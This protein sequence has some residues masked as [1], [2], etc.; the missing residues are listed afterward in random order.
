MLK[1]YNSFTAQ[2]EIFKPIKA[3]HISLYVC[4]ITVYDYCHLG[5]ARVF[6]CFD[7]IVRYLR[8]R[9]WD[10]TYIRNITDVD[11]KIIKRAAERDESIEV[12]TGYFIEAMHEDER[13]LKV[14]SP[15]KEPRATQH[16]QTMI[17]MI[18]KLESRGVAYQGENGDLFFSV[19]KYQTYGA[20]S[21][22]DLSE[23]KSGSRVE[24]D[25][26]KRN[27]LDFVL[28]KQAKEGETSWPSPW[29]MGRP[30]WHIE[31]SAMSTKCLGHTFDIHGGGH[32]LLFPHHENERAQS[33]CATGETFVNTW[34]HVGF[35]QVDKEKMSKSLNN[36]FTIRDVLKEYEPEAVRYF[37]IAGHYRSPINYSTQQ[38]T[39]A[40]AALDRL[41]TAIRGLNLVVPKME[42]IYHKR[43][44][45][46]MDDDFNTPDALA[47]LFDLAHEIN[48]LKDQNR[49]SASEK[50]G[51]LQA[52]AQ[53]LGLLSQDPESYFQGDLRFEAIEALV[54]E[55]EAA[56]KA[57]DWERADTIRDQLKAQGVILEDTANGISWRKVQ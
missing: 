40:K 19:E 23:L 1:I 46:A 43:F 9:E 26:N 53:S 21:K 48:T 38:L 10:V 39:H 16:I 7:T 8:S 30:G 13:A 24:I 36:F 35:V 17:D 29:G 41:Y 57:K 49:E 56:R 12:L 50:A 33:E 2:K 37:L 31:C 4:G 6:V 27:P 15:T 42:T 45:E 51:I 18:Q 11:D 54:A 25:F 20:L 32:D 28:W 47:V 5:H 14:L 52:L 44:Y 3:K 55:R 22:R 34:M